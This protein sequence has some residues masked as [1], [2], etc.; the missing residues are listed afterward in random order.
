MLLLLIMV[1]WLRVS[2]IIG[3][4][5]LKYLMLRSIIQVRYDEIRRSGKGLLS[6]P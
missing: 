5:E 1:T 4:L 3:R 2:T 6:I